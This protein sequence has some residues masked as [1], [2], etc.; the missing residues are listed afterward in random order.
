MNQIVNKIKQE[1]LGFS[2]KDRINLYYKF[3]K[4]FPGGYGE[5]DIFAGIKNPPLRALSKKYKTISIDDAFLLLE[6]EIHEIRLLA[7]FILELKVKNKKIDP[8]DF[9]RIAEL[10]LK[11]IP[12]I[13]NWD[14]V[15][16]SAHHILGF[17]VYTNSSDVLIKLAQK[18]HLWS[19]R[20]AMIATFYHIRKQDYDLPLRIAELLVHHK[21][22]L[23][24]KAVGW[25]L[26]EIGKRDLDME[27][28][29]LDKYYKIMP[30]TMLRYA[31]EKFEESLRKSYL[32]GRFS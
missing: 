29:F 9:N 24:H 11:H 17:W 8:D 20:I 13:N 5:G 12:F 1:A 21:H 19:N 4:C 3:F 2:E 32:T 26:R 25:M 14:L 6:D 30:R 22:D 23:I 27:L 31:I 15:D 10:Y 18:E 7:L 28:K 16:A